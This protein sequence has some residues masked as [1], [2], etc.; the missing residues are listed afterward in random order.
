MHPSTAQLLD[1][2]AYDHLPVHLQEQSKPFSDLAHLM[3][4]RSPV[5]G[6]E[7]TV[8][9]RKLLEAKDAF[10]RQQARVEF[11]GDPADEA[12]SVT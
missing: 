6:P 11:L 2:F 1:F 8:A 5:G 4:D 3:V 12:A 10:V 9:L 7:L